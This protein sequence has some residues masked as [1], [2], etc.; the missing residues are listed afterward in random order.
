M[1]TFNSS[2][3]K[4]EAGRSLSLKLVWSTAS[5]RTDVATQR[6]IISKNKTKKNLYVS[7]YVPPHMCGGQNDSLL[8]L[9]G[10]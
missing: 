10:P 6:N 7:V 8:P 5:S 2:I 4:A 9:R 1:H 3:W